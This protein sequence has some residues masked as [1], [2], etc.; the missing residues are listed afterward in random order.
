MASQSVGRR[1]QIQA[2]RTTGGNTRRETGVNSFFSCSDTS[3][4]R[5]NE[6]TP[7]ILPQLAFRV[8]FPPYRFREADWQISG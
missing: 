4:E 6:L 3:F 2:S 8:F 5:K 7:I 1:Y